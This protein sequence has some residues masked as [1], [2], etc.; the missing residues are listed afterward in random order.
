MDIRK[1]ILSDKLMDYLCVLAIL[2][3][4]F[5]AVMCVADADAAE[6]QRIAPGPV[7]VILT[8]EPSQKAI[9]DALVWLGKRCVGSSFDGTASFDGVPAGTYVLRV[10]H[11]DYD[12]HLQE[13]VLS[14]GKRQAIEIE[15]H[16][17]QRKR[18]AGRV[19]LENGTAVPGARIVVKPLSVPASISGS[20]DFSTDWQGN[21]ELL[22]IPAGNYVVELSAFGCA[23]TRFELHTSAW[24][25][26]FTLSART[27][28]G[29]LLVQVRDAE[30][31]QSLSGARVEISE[32]WP[33]GTIGERTTD[34][35]GVVQFL[36]LQIGQLNWMNG[37]RQLSVTRPWVTVRVEADGYAPQLQI[38]N[39]LARGD[40]GSALEVLLHASEPVQEEES[41]DSI[42]QAQNIVPGRPVVLSI[43]RNGDVDTFTFRLQYPA[44][45]QITAQS[46][47]IET[48]LTLF[49]VNGERLTARGGR[50]VKIMSLIRDSRPVFIFLRFV[51]GETTPP[52][53]NHSRSVSWRPPRRILLS[54]M[55]EKIRHG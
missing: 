52:V 49:D 25:D 2:V 50:S 3:S 16:P 29:R 38:V 24:P 11:L 35:Q 43:D 46:P 33:L 20:Y 22:E 47:P 21:Y 42:V 13:I 18:L 53:S 34:T 55:T 30:S 27:G 45:L 36:G 4:L 12:E 17:T 8:S 37:T 15:L 48:Y 7:T 51:N 14:A 54:P 26:V 6:G 44:R 10:Q 5:Q 1:N 31:G 41:N 19:T 23:P 39:L 40:M 9:A 28:P 32:S